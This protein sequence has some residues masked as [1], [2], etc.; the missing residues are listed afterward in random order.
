MKFLAWDSESE[1][2]EVFF[3]LVE[4]LGSLEI[5]EDIEELIEDAIDTDILI[6]DLDGNIKTIEKNIK[7]LKKAKKE[8]LIL[9]LT[10]KLDQSKI[11]KHQKSK[12]AGT[13]YLRTPISQ[14]TL[15]AVLQPFVEED[16]SS[17][18]KIDSRDVLKA[19][20]D[21]GE[22][23]SEAQDI[24]DKLDAQF[25][26]AMAHDDQE[27]IAAEEP[28][29][30]QEE[31]LDKM[32]EE[33]TV[34]QPIPKQDKT[35]PLFDISAAQDELVS[36]IDDEIS[37]HDESDDNFSDMIDL[38]VNESGVEGMSLNEKDE[39]IN[40]EV[41]DLEENALDLEL[42]GD[43]LSLSDESEDL[44]SSNFNDD[45]GLEF[46]E[47]DENEVDISL[48]PSEDINDIDNNEAGLDLELSNEEDIA[49]DE[50]SFETPSESFDSPEESQLENND[51][52]A[53][54]SD[55][56][57]IDNNFDDL[58][59]DGVI[60]NDDSLNLAQEN[61]EESLQDSLDIDLEVEANA[62]ENELDQI[63]QLN[64]IED[65]LIEDGLSSLSADQLP[66]APL[67]DEQEEKVDANISTNAK[68][69]LA[70]ID[71]M[72]L[73]EES[74]SEIEDD[75][76]LIKEVNAINPEFD[77]LVEDNTDILETKEVYQSNK[78]SSPSLDHKEV[79]NEVNSYN[80]EELARLGE[81]IKNLR[82]DR[83][84]LIGRIFD[85]EN[86]KNNEKNEFISLKAEIDERKIELKLTRKR[87]EKKLED[88]SYH[89]DISEQKR[90]MLEEKNKKLELEVNKL[91]QKNNIDLNRI[92][93]RETELENKLELLR[94]DSESQI[95]N[96]DLKIL[97]LKRR[98]DTLEFDIE[99]MHA[100]ERKVI[101]SNGE[102]EDKMEKVIRTLRHAIGELE[103][104]DSTINHL[105][106]VKKS[107]D[108]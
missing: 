28:E 43:D 5:Y 61:A 96:R 47:G 6:F 2:L 103:D 84:Q 95:K 62:F 102:L 56:D 1:A 23:S 67:I 55:S 69:Q 77:P 10:N 14:D 106:K 65:D 22:V 83:E 91:A 70:E 7:K 66:G 100:K 41:L 35:D 86:E 87:Y 31:I 93:S 32:M 8:C 18:S 42:S 82:E 33:N 98:I 90:A 27:V 30:S 44:N 63:D 58:S 51:S 92:R 74:G 68:R 40:K 13:L 21:K 24:S 64:V 71:K 60:D 3:D 48:T 39:D 81:V 85:L 80:T 59:G 46:D 94:E 75:I 73:D 108:I 49:I 38:N 20:T 37:D 17:A 104:N 79:S 89:L 15:I 19:H 34:I 72:L 12:F 105:E 16:L 99:S 76:G 4:D 88:L 78:I 45:D 9:Y 26:Q 54:L 57:S 107:L 29:L 101:D 53:S 97:E 11:E 52:T 36:E 50:L 25:E